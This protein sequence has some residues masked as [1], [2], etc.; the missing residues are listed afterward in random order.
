MELWPTQTLVMWEPATD[1][2]HYTKVAE[3]V[4]KNVPEKE[5]VANIRNWMRNRNTVEFIGLWETLNNPNFKRVEFD[6]FRNQA[7]LNSFNLTPKKLDM[8]KL[9]YSSVRDK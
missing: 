1:W 9:L 7:G 5:A 8:E 4:E 6:T 3:Q 2:W